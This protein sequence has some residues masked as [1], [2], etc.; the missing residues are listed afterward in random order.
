MVTIRL[1]E[2]QNAKLLTDNASNGWRPMA[3]ATMAIGHQSDS[4][5]L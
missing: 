4:G 3:M 2:I 1:V 5:Y